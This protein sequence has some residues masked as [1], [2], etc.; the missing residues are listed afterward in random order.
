MSNSKSYCSRSFHESKAEEL[1]PFALGVKAGYYGNNPPFTDVTIT[2]VAFGLLI[3]TYVNK[4]GDYVNGGET[5]KGPFLL[6]KAALME[7][8]DSLADKTDLVAA[9]NPDIVTL[10]GYTPTKVGNSDSNKPGQCVVSVKRGIAGELVATCEILPGA[11]YYGCIMVAGAPLPPWFTITDGG[12]VMIDLSFLPPPAALG[13][14]EPVVK[15]VQCD[16]TS[17]RVKHFTGLKH[18]EVYY[19]YF[20]AVN[21]AGVGALSE[22]VSMVCW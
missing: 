10:A 8:L 13:A 9:G 20:Y 17:Q 4:R 16:L 7:G 12:K 3:T 14:E 18:D 21:A 15:G 6:A 5:Q 1:D 19:F 11:K 2:E 22:G